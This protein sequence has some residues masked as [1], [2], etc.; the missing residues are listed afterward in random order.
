MKR[1]G[2]DRLARFSLACALLLAVGET[3]VLLTRGKYWPLSLDDYVAAGA[4]ALVAAWVRP[5]LRATLLPCAWAFALGNL[6]AMLCT[7]LDP[8]TG[9]GE[10]VGLLAFATALAAVG[11]AWSL[12]LA[13][14]HASGSENP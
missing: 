3:L 1:A 13:V 12:Q 14:R 8:A 4:L 7:R 10:R 2:G 5:A 11:L 9:T 6:Y